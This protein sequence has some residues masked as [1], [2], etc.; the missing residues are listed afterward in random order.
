M[1]TEEPIN[2]SWNAVLV[3]GYWQLVDC[4]WAT[5]YL[6]SERNVPENLVYEYDDFYF[7]P[8]PHELVYSHCPEDPAWQLVYPARSRAEF[9][10]YP[11]VK[12]YFFTVGMQFCQQDK[13]ILHTRNGILVL[14]LAA[15]KPAQF[16]FKLTFGEAMV[17]MISSVSLKRYVIQET[18]DNRLT[19]YFRCPREGNYYLTIFAQQAGNRVR[20]EYVFKA[21]CEFKII[22]DQA[23]ADTRPYPLCSDSNWGPGAPVHQYGF[24]PSHKDAIVVAE[25]GRVDISFQKSRNVRLFARLTQDGADQDILERYVSVKEQDNQV[26]I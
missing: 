12:S 18:V 13:G 26:S 7:F 9:E 21:T 1:I 2:H 6:Q 19:F 4:H 11:L 14:T 16:T 23:A 8:P 10:D 17:E 20:T 5:R 25:R 3:D 22:C 24:T 15:T